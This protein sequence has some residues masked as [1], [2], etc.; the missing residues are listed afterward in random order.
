MTANRRY[1][2]VA[3]DLRKAIAERGVQVGERLMTERKISEDM[4]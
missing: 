3:Y 2:D 1:Q 4:G